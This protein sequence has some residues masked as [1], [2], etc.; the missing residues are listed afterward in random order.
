MDAQ[1]SLLGD[2]SRTFAVT[3]NRA[4]SKT[5]VPVQMAARSPN[6]LNSRSQAKHL[7]LR[8][9]RF[10]TVVLD[11]KDV[12]QSGR[13]F[14]DQIFR[15]YAR[16]HPGLDLQFVNTNEEVLKMIR[17]AQNAWGEAV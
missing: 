9:D 2:A 16:A 15:V 14:A 12:N 1:C 4:I 7:S 6:D 5:V 10:R 17:R 11:F 3:P 13:A 8:M